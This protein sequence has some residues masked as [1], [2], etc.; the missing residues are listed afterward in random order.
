MNKDSSHGFLLR[1]K[2]F[3][4]V[5]FCQGQGGT[6]HI[7][8]IL[9]SFFDHSIIDSQSLQKIQKQKCLPDKNSRNQSSEKQPF[10]VQTIWSYRGLHD[11]I[12]LMTLCYFQVVLIF[13]SILKFWKKNSNFEKFQTKGGIS[14]HD[15]KGVS[16]G[17]MVYSN[18][19]TCNQFKKL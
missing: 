13:S 16:R 2:N 17:T 19:F 5:F 12:D 9:E 1:S 14:R 15:M 3:F 6:D 7:K 18:V 4:W 8:L 10:R 11:F